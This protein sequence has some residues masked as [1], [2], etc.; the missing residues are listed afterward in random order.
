MT[1]T[2]DQPRRT[3]PFAWLPLLA[4]VVLL[5]ASALTGRGGVASDAHAANTVTVTGL[6]N[7]LVYLDATGCSGPAALDIGD[8]VPD[9]PWKR[10]AADCSILFGTSNSPLGADLSVL[11]DPAAPAAPADAMKCSVASCTGGSFDG[12]INDVAANSTAPS[13]SASAFGAQLESATGLATAGWTA[14]KA[15]PVA[16]AST[17]CS[18]TNVGDGTCAFRFGAS[19]NTTDG[20]GSYQAQVQFL[21][22]AR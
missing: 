3:T 18:T 2:A 11:E 19:A 17:A 5:M 4:L 22:L 12:A 7:K 13:T 15:N 1:T 6:V 10:T 21:V 9:D 8:L 16:A 14:G 20:P